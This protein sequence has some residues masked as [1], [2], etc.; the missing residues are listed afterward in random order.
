MSYIKKLLARFKVV[1]DWRLL[2]IAIYA[3]RCSILTFLLQHSS[4]DATV[5][6]A[7]EGENKNIDALMAAVMSKDEE[8]VRIV[9]NDDRIN[10]NFV[11]LFGHSAL[12][13]AVSGSDHYILDML[14]RDP[15]IDVNIFLRTISSV[16]AVNDSASASASAAPDTASRTVLMHA[17]SQGD[18]VCIRFLLKHPSIDVNAVN[19]TGETAAFYMLRG[20]KRFAN[21]F[22]FDVNVGK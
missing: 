13:M 12:K 5:L 19:E 21:E 7:Q 9:L 3:R 18:P 4:I 6:N 15:R 20:L 2:E 17:M 22:N 8:I 16:Q 11:S 14:L 1:P 10:V